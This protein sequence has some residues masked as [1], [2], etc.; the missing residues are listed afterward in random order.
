[1]NDERLM[2]YWMNS[3]LLL[4][5]SDLSFRSLM[6]PNAPIACPLGL[7]MAFVLIQINSLPD[8]FSCLPILIIRHRYGMDVAQRIILIP[9]QFCQP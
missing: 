6:K 9:A 3:R 1:M 8:V 4:L 2:S 7:C 5:F